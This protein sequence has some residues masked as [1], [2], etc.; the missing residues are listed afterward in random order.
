MDCWE[1]EWDGIGMGLGLD[2][3]TGIFFGLIFVAFFWLLS[4]IMRRFALNIAVAGRVSELEFLTFMDPVDLN[5]LRS[6]LIENKMK[7]KYNT[8]AGDAF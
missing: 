2:W 3:G 8:S 1:W 5:D 4:L 7:L 6:Q